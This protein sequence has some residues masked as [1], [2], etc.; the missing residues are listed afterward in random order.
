VKKHNLVKPMLTGWAD[1]APE[2]SAKGGRPTAFVLAV[3]IAI[4]AVWA[5]S[6]AILPPPPAAAPPAA[7]PAF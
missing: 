4:A 7:A 6:G 5:A 1:G 3:L 2:Q